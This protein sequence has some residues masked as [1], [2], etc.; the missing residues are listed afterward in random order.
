MFKS[1]RCQGIAFCEFVDP[2]ITDIAIQGLHG[3]VIG[4][5]NLK[6]RKASIG[7]TQVSGVEMGVNAMSMLAGTTASGDS[8][9]SRVVQLLNMVAPE[10]L[11]D[12]DDYEGEFPVPPPTLTELTK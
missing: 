11:L 5:K 9:I 1:N 6:V 2:S 4:E 12:N 10:E 3:M 7:I 8:E